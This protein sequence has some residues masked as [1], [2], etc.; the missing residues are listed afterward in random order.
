MNQTWSRVVANI[1]ITSHADLIV[2]QDIL[3]NINFGSTATQVVTLGQYNTTIGSNPQ[4]LVYLVGIYANITNNNLSVSA[5]SGGINPSFATVLVATGG[6]TS[7]INA[8][9]ISVIF[10]PGS[11]QF[12]SYA[13]VVTYRSFQQ[14]YLNLYNSFVPIYYSLVGMSGIVA[15]GSNAR[16]YGYDMTIN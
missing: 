9:I 7:L 12:L 4:H 16:F 15:S 5:S 2:R 11:S 3:T 8:T 10:T 1:W 13:G 6:T 14:E